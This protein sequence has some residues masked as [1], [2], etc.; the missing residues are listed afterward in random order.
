MMKVDT[1]K[2]IIIILAALLVIS[3]GYIAGLKYK[4]YSE[5][6]KSEYMEEGFKKG[7]EYA[8][9]QLANEASGC[10]PVQIVANNVTM[11]LIAEECL[12]MPANSSLGN[13]GFFGF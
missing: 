8:V 13:L 5:K 6:K 2:I 9:L 12:R 4:E 3:I 11:N 10:Q 7:Y 1:Q